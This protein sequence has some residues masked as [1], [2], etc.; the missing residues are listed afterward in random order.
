MEFS[1]ITQAYWLRLS[2]LISHINLGFYLK[3]CMKNI[4]HM[5]PC[6]SEQVYENADK[7]SNSNLISKSKSKSGKTGVVKPDW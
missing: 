1:K 3:K 7:S 6:V 2:T 4:M 5:N